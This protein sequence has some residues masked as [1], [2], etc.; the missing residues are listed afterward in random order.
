V[1]GFFLLCWVSD[2]ILFPSHNFTSNYSIVYCTETFDEIIEF[3]TNK[4]QFKTL[5]KHLRNRRLQR[6]N[7][8]GLAFSLKIVFTL[9]AL[10]P[11]QT[12][13]NI[14]VETFVILDVSSNVSMFAHPWKHCCGNICDSRCFL[15]CFHVCPPV[16]TLLRKQNLLPGKQK[17]FL[18]TSETFD[19][20]L[21]FSLMFP[22]VFAHSGKHGETLVGNN[23][24]ATM[25][26]SLPRV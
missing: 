25:C 22:I 18:Q 2:E 14:V 8:R 15:K 12:I 7:M 17:C 20:S 9:Q 10:S 16:E 1:S 3:Q 19:V 24:S 5:K 6:P 21:C 13:G 23:V 11:G 4:P 26:P